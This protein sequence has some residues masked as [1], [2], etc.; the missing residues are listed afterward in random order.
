MQVCLAWHCDSPQTACW[1]VAPLTSNKY[2]LQ[3]LDIQLACTL[4]RACHSAITLPCWD[5]TVSHAGQLHQLALSVFAVQFCSL[6]WQHQGTHARSL[7]IRVEQLRS[8]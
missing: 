8:V 7:A 4:S 3:Q 6:I 5:S 1:H 2:Y